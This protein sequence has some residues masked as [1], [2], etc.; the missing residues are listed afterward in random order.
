MA[1]TFN[2]ET[3]GPSL[4]SPLRFSPIFLK[5]LLPSVAVDPSVSRVFWFVS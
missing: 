2:V 4:F 3:Q 1:Y 5:S